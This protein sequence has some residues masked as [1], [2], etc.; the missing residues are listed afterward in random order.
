MNVKRVALFVLF[1]S[2]LAAGLVFAQTGREIR[3]YRS[4]DNDTRIRI[5]RAVETLSGFDIEYEASGFLVGPG[6]VQFNVEA[7]FNDGSTRDYNDWEYVGTTRRQWVG[8][9]TA[10]WA[11]SSQIRSLDVWI[12]YGDTPDPRIFR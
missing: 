11:R 1:I 3:V 6:W 10:P 8:M 12:N 7:E 2:V 4:W 5:I 9:V